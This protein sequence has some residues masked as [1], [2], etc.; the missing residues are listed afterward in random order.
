[1]IKKDISLN[2]VTVFD[3]IKFE[4]NQ[5]LF[6]DQFQIILKKSLDKIFQET[7]LYKKADTS[8]KKPIFFLSH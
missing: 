8:K 2:R 4:E 7:S 3:F 5:D 6:L 1:M